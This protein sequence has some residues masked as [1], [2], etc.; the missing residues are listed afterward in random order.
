M[1][2][3]NTKNEFTPARRE[4]SVHTPSKNAQGEVVE[5]TLMRYDTF[6]YATKRPTINFP[7]Y[8]LIADGAE[9]AAVLD[10]LL[11]VALDN[12]LVWPHVVCD[13]TAAEGPL[14][15]DS[16]FDPVREVRQQLALFMGA[17]EA[18]DVIADDI[19]SVARLADDGS[20]LA[21]TV[22]QGAD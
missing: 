17:K 12:K 18:L 2:A 22:A 1:K 15:V 3:T 16:D 13:Y 14:V 10:A 11:Q 6:H 21:E 9:F 7:T 5:L 4:L 20:P 19:Q 8:E